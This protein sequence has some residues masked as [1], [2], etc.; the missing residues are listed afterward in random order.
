M[1]TFSTKVSRH[2][3]EKIKL[4]EVLQKITGLDFPTLAEAAAKGAIWYQKLSKGKILRL[5][6]LHVPIQPEDTVTF[7][8]DAHV[9]SLPEVTYAECLFETS[10]YG[11]WVKDAGVMP[12][13][14][15]TGDHTSLLR[16][17]EKI[18]KKDVFLIHRLDRE[19]KG[20]MVIGY[21]SQAAGRLSE[22]FLKNQITKT[23][24]AIVR[25][26]LSVGEKRTINQSLDGK[27]AITH[28]EV[29]KSGKGLTLL[30]LTIET[31]RLHQIRRHLEIIGHPV[32]GDP[33]YGRGNKN[34]EGLQLM[35][36]SLSFIDPWTKQLRLIELDQDLSLPTV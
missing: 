21:E 17:V 12:Q 27:S 8:Y 18:K 3:S 2:F 19:T 10:Y 15:Q 5:R 23:Y 4:G 24:L 6:S 36:K 16:Y 34:R 14:S 29:L 31:G 1:K 22:L 32:M 35:A 9:L 7:Y 30:K 25:G 20:L 13:G 28:F 26:E 11:V 33:K